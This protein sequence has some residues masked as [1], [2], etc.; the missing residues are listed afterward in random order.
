MQP[1]MYS[2]SAVSN[3][4]LRCI[5]DRHTVLCKG[6]GEEGTVTKSNAPV[7]Y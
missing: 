5:E 4:L 2:Y 3:G 1:Q 6:R 7:R